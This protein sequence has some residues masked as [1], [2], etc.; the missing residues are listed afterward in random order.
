MALEQLIKRKNFPTAEA[1]QAE[2][3]R[4]IQEFGNK[5]L[6]GAK[7]NIPDPRQLGISLTMTEFGAEKDVL[8][9]ICA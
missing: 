1:Q 2:V 8:D 7:A 6:N 4:L 5:D 3:T 9:I